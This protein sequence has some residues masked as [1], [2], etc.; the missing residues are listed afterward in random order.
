MLFQHG[1]RKFCPSEQLR[2]ASLR[3]WSWY[4]VNTTNQT[5]LSINRCNAQGRSCPGLLWLN[6]CLY[7]CLVCQTVFVTDSP[8]II[9][10]NHICGGNSLKPGSSKL[11]HSRYFSKYLILPKNIVILISNLLT[12]S[13]YWS[14]LGLGNA[15]NV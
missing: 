11:A 13:L 4:S 14:K 5:I 2:N 3:K 15:R 7:W 9:W 8:I 1:N 12:T 6:V 10:H